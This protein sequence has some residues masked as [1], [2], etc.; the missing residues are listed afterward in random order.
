MWFQLELGLPHHVMATTNEVQSELTQA[1][2]FLLNF[3]SEFV[4][5]L[6]FYF[7]FNCVLYM[8]L[9]YN[10]R[11]LSSGGVLRVILVFFL[12]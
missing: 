11:K 1:K 7:T 5:S 10:I 3:G 8:F 6:L 12:R 4:W 9:I 2:L